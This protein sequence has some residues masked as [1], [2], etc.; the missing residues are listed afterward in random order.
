[1]MFLLLSRLRFFFSAHKKRIVPKNN[2]QM[3]HV[4][5]K[6]TRVEIRR[7]AAVFTEMTNIALHSLSLCVSAILSRMAKNVKV[8]RPVC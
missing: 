4:F 5:K 7:P 1:M 8:G 3:K 6:E 2:S